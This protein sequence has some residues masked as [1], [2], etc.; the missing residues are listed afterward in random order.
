MMA[1]GPVLEQ[2]PPLFREDRRYAAGLLSSIIKDD[3]YE[4]L[5]TTSMG[6]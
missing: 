6:P 5:G 2:C 3:D 1:K 4:D